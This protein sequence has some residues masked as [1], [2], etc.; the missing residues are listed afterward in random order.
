MKKRR[1]LAFGVTLATTLGLFAATLPQQA[2]AA[3][4]LPGENGYVSLHKYAYPTST[5]GV[6]KIKL[7]VLGKIENPPPA[8]DIVVYLDQSG[9]MT[10]GAGVSA[11][12]KAHLALDA[13]LDV[14][15]DP[16]QAAALN[17][18]PSWFRIGLIGF[19]SSILNETTSTTLMGGIDPT[20][21]AGANAGMIPYS[22]T[23]KTAFSSWFNALT[24]PGGTYM[25][26]AANR[27]FTTGVYF[28]A[29]TSTTWKTADN[30]F[31]VIIAD[32][33]SSN[34]VTIL[35]PHRNSA[36]LTN[37]FALAVDG[38]GFVH[39]PSVVPF[40]VSDWTAS[41]STY[42]AL[43]AAN[44]VPQA[45][46][47]GNEQALINIAT[48]FPAGTY[49]TAYSATT[50]SSGTAFL[51]PTYRSTALAYHYYFANTAAIAQSAFT[52]I[53]HEIVA[54]TTPPPAGAVV[55]DK[56]TNEFELI[57]FPGAPL[58]DVNASDGSDPGTAS[59]SGNLI[60]WNLPSPL[61]SGVSYTLT[62]YVK[63]G[64]DL[65]AGQYYAT[66]EYA[67]ISYEFEGTNYNF[68]FP[69]P[70]VNVV[71][72]ETKTEETSSSPGI[73]TST[74]T[75]S[76]TS[77]SGGGLL[78]IVGSLGNNGQPYT[79]SVTPSQKNATDEALEEGIKENNLAE[80]SAEV[81]VTSSQSLIVILAIAMAGAAIAI[82]FFK[83]RNRQK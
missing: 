63:A 15:W 48:E 50:L 40:E 78:P 43:A 5:D 32:G 38:N 24:S 56:I 6:F 59:N 23:N 13:M 39:Y 26:A 49:P 79:P 28:D 64:A 16:T 8:V 62:Y 61:L 41:H 4:P 46:S 12:Q 1:L 73:D 14:L 9:S 10:G 22:P 27:S 44:R 67:T 25:P 11:Q 35:A 42:G 18:D 83:Q 75:P 69:K 77:G 29:P 82:V 54:Q 66:N 80:K 21:L 81:P 65:D 31:V 51:N 74:Y 20:S 57:K 2:S 53:A 19:T 71:S 72:G 30:R 17:A 76:T 34:T 60:T 58:L 70:Y 3:A 37:V 55:A 7:E 68:A 33:D 45:T 52:D 36:Y 47:A